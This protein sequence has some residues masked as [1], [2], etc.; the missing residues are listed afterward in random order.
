MNTSRFLLVPASPFDAYVCMQWQQAASI[1]SSPV[2]VVA[3][4]H[5]V[6]ALL[7]YLCCQ[8]TVHACGPPQSTL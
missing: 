3:V 2:S 6:H 4:M 5:S 7:F 1:G 8:S